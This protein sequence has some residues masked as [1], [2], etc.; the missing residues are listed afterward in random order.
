MIEADHWQTERL[1]VRP[2][3]PADADEVFELLDD[4]CLHEFTGD[5]PLP[6]AELAARYQRLAQRV[7][8]DGRQVWAN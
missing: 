4:E 3:E 6:R 5:A 8:P 7:S 2:L 1:D